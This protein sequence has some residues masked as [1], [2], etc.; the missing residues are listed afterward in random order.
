MSLHICLLTPG[1]LSTNPRIVKEADA[2]VE[3]GHRVHVISADYSDW[4]RRADAEF[5]TASTGRS[6]KLPLRSGGAKMHQISSACDTNRRAHPRTV[7]G[8]TCRKRGS[9]GLSRGVARS[10][11]ICLCACRADL[12]VAHY[13]AALPAAAAAAKRHRAIYAFDAEDFHLGDLPDAKVHAA[14]KRLIRNIE[15]R[16]LPDCAYVTAASPG[17]SGKLMSTYGIARPQVLLN[18][19]PSSEAPSRPTSAGNVRPGP[20]VYWFSQTIGRDRGLECAVRAIAKAISRPHLYLRGIPS[21]SFRSEIEAIA[22]SLGVADRL[23][24]LPP[25]APGEMVAL[26]ADYDLGLVGETGTTLN[27]RIALTNKQFTYLLAGVPILMSAV[28]AHRDFAAQ[29]GDAAKLYPVDDEQALAEC[30][31]SWLLDETALDASRC[32]AW[33]LGQEQFNW[34]V[35][36]RKLIDIVSHLSLSAATAHA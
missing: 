12:Y 18:V 33:R 19:F 22:A 10:R 9:V 26:A 31:D 2:L 7:A 20:S 4:A 27:R 5:E 23:H 35:E 3:A 13:V 30:M 32:T 1:H 24:L 21:P 25:A 17:I 28:P 15:S 6:T 29:C 14:E 11:E 8:S 34:E 16:Y 36:K